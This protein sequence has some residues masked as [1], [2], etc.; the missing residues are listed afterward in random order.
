MNIVQEAEKYVS[1]LI[2]D[3]IKAIY[4]YHNLE[5][6]QNVVKH[7]TK[8]AAELEFSEEQTEILILAAWFHDSGYYK[9]FDNHEE[10]SARNARSFLE[11]KWNGSEGDIRRQFLCRRES[12]T[13]QVIQ[14]RDEE[15]I[16]SVRLYLAVA[17]GVLTLSLFL[18]VIRLYLDVKFL[19][20]LKLRILLMKRLHAS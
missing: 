3:S 11:D 19:H 14:A 2:E 5:H 1:M 6:T 8:I 9:D 10:I 13:V 15:G 20:A 16:T 18:A 12:C 17:I 4:T 7:A